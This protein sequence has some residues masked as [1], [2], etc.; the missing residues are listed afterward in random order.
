MRRVKS[1]LPRISLTVILLFAILG[2]SS[3]YAQGP[4][5]LTGS[6]KM[7]STVID[8]IIVGDVDNHLFMITESKGY[9]KGTG[10]SNLFD[11]AR[12]INLA[13]IDVV[14]GS[15]TQQGYLKFSK[16]SSVAH[17][18][19]NGNAKTVVDDAGKKSTT[20]E[21]T[22]TFTHGTGD[23]EMIKGGGTFTGYYTSPTSYIADGEGEYTLE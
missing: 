8:S 11:G 6:M 5:K 21:G 7:N 1:G 10:E 13:F 22:F 14:M 12:A 9:N 20:F 3:L 17:F 23:Y 15:G 16:N 18:K 4:V 19:W 2:V